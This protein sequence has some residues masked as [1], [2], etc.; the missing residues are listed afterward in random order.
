MDSTTFP[1]IVYHGTDGVSG[2]SI[3]RK[4]LDL[5]AWKKLGE[6]F[7]IDDKGFSVTGNRQVATAWAA[8]RAGER[9]TPFGAILQ[10]KAEALPLRRGEPGTWTD[11][12]AFYVRPEDFCLVAPGIFIEQEVVAALS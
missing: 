12:D 8:L 7:P 5:G 10:A 9:C 3:C 11:P 2:E 4:G 6:H 1:E